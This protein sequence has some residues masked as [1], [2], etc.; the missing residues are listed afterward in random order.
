M[1]APTAGMSIL[2]K[3]NQ[4]EV[5]FNKNY[6]LNLHQILQIVEGDEG[7]KE[8]RQ[9]ELLSEAYEEWYNK[10]QDNP[11][12]IDSVVAYYNAVGEGHELLMKRD[13]QLFT[14]YG[15]FLSNAFN[16]PGLD[17]DF[18]FDQLLDGLDDVDESTPEEERDAKDN[19]WNMAIGLYRL[20]A[21]ICIY[22]KMPL[23][24]EIIDMLLMDN[25]NLNQSNMFANI[26]AKFKGSKRLRRMIM[27]LMKSKEDNF[28][29]IFTSL[30]KVIATFSSEVN[31][32]TNMKAN[33]EAAK[34][35]VRAAFEQILVE[36]EVKSLTDA[37][38]TQLIE[39]LEEQKED[40]LKDFV[41]EG[42]LAKE[43]L[44]KV[45]ELYKAKNLDKMQVNKVVKDLGKTMTDMM[46]AIETND[47]KAIESLLS[48]AGSGLNLP[49]AELEKMQSE[50]EK[51]EKI[52][53]EDDDDEEEAMPELVSGS[54]ETTKTNA[55]NEMD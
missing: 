2:E 31:L 34:Q 7:E 9:A 19:F 55:V 15:D 51:L 29:E 18:L 33:L 25:P 21:M 53:E 14:L 30:Q 16:K 36:A 35:R 41:S 47:E 5:N 49:T 42:I 1:A 46:A 11:R 32:D 4:I 52:D 26:F 40:A 37:Q 23:V 38:T 6:L 24:R 8:T 27:K 20:T 10:L 43:K 45:R 39:A 22:L 54:A 44:E 13:R 50:M 12:C 3:F 28:G 17:T 48:R